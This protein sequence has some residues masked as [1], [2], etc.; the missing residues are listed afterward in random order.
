MYA[1]TEN[2]QTITLIFNQSILT[3]LIYTSDS[4]FRNFSI[5]V[6]E[7]IERFTL[8]AVNSIFCIEG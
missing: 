3:K 8:F 5:S 7:K 6:C 4:V 2:V 1:C